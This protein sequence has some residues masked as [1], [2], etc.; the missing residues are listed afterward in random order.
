MKKVVFIQEIVPSYRIPFFTKVSKSENIDFWVISSEGGSEE[1]FEIISPEKT[2]F[3]WVIL[4]KRSIQLFSKQIIILSNLIRKI[5]VIKPDIIITTGNK[6]VI[7]NNLLI[8]LKKLIGY[9]LFYH[10]HACFYGSASKLFRF[11]EHIYTKYYLTKYLDGLILYTEYE[12]ER[13][14]KKGFNSKKLFFL[15]NTI[16]VESISKIRENID[17]QFIDK[18]LDYY[19]IKKSPSIVFI[20][21]LIPGKKIEILF[22]YFEKVKKIM[23]QIQLIIIGDGPLFNRLRKN[24]IKN[25][26]NIILTGKLYDESKIAAI[27]TVCR[28]IFLPEYSGLSINHAF[29]YGKPFITLESK[30]HGPEIDY[31]KNDINGFIL[32]E[33]NI[34]HNIEL[35]LRL[36]HDERYFNNI[37]RNCIE[38]A[39]NL[40]MDKMVK[41]FLGI[42]YDRKNK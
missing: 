3:R 22:N 7:Q 23:P 18:T 15:D 26:E 32:N 30:E 8:F 20:G 39:R 12:K 5:L 31:I 16:D 9:K 34:N 38:T 37:S 28:F 17:Q 40:T 36:L 2:E 21:R 42:I 1:G 25:T 27:M 29:A 35:M 6:S 13:M 10:Q 24:I 41:Y 33:Q 11:L 19:Q 14:V 4:K